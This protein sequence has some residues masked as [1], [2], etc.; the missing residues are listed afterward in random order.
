MECPECSKTLDEKVTNP[1][2]Q[3]EAT[4]LVFGIFPTTVIV[5]FKAPEVI[6]YSCKCGYMNQEK[7]Y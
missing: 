1:I 3:I 7:N 2:E 6:E 4:D 5:G